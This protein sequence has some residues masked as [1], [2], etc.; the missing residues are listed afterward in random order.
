MFGVQI[1]KIMRVAVKADGVAATTA[2][3]EREGVQF[4]SVR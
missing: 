1:K 2:E 3:G 4:S